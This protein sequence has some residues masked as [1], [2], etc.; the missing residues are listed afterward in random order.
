VGE[1]IMKDVP[2]FR[3]DYLRDLGETS[4]VGGV[5]QAIAVPSIWAA[6]IA[7]TRR[8]YASTAV[9]HAPR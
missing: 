1:T 5:Q 4:K 2:A 7:R 8:L 6:R 9:I 3:R